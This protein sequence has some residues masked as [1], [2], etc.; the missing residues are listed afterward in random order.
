VSS[1]PE[2]W[3]PAEDRL[4]THVLGNMPSIVRLEGGPLDY[5]TGKRAR[6][7]ALWYRARYSL[8]VIEMNRLSANL[9]DTTVTA[10]KTRDELERVE[11]EVAELR[12]RIE[13]AIDE[14][15]K[16]PLRDD[17][18]LEFL[19]DI[20]TH[21]DLVYAGA[22]DLHTK[23]TALASGSGGVAAL[24]GLPVDLAPAFARSEEQRVA[25]EIIARY[26]KGT[27]PAYIEYALACIWAR[28]ARLRSSD[29][30][31]AITRA[32]EHLRRA[33]RKDATLDAR[34]KRDPDLKPVA[35]QLGEWLRV[36]DR[37][38]EDAATTPQEEP[39]PAPLAESA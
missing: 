2:D 5:A 27:W 26:S 19:R 15:R 22:L 4:R 28:D 29:T 20:S 38:L 16:R 35:T 36:R 8:A 1:E 6:H 10:E 33:I 25:V 13:H 34:W 37:A 17:P 9:S 3:G 11:R 32:G 23:Y 39:S 30:D 24:P 14:S 18:L 31:A 12:K 21:V 7:R